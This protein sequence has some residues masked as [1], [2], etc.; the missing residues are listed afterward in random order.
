M[1]EH[2][3]TTHRALEA[4]VTVAEIEHALYRGA[5]NN[6]IGAL[7]IIKCSHREVRMAPPKGRTVV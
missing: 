7:D 5:L 6:G 3:L 1:P 4:G 2:P